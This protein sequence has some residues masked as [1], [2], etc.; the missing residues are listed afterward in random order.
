M[1]IPPL[2]SLEDTCA[3]AAQQTTRFL[4]VMA[5]YSMRRRSDNERDWSETGKVKL[6]CGSR[7]HVD[8]PALAER[9]AIVDAYHDSSA[10]VQIGNANQGAERK[11][12]MRRRE[13]FGQKWLATRGLRSTFLR[14]NRGNVACA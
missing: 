2:P 5:P 10:V 11:S 6:R 9:P 12:A 1:I 7:R 13:F 4:I 14:A 3:E 8:D